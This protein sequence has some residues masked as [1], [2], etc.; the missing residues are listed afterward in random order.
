MNV[1]RWGI[2][3]PIPAALVFVV[4]CVF[5]FW[6][7]R[8]LPI[9]TLP[10][11]TPPEID[12]TVTL[13]GASPS[14]L[15]TDVT[16]KVEDAVA[17]IANID[18]LLSTVNE[19]QSRTRILFELGR[20]M[21]TALEEVRDAIDRVRSELPP[22]IDE[23]QITRLTV[24]GPIML[25]Y[26]V[27]S[28][29]LALDE[30]S[31][32]VD[33]TVKKVL[34]GTPGV[35]TVSRIGGLDRE[36]RVDL[37]PDMLQAFGLTAGTVSMQL[38]RIQV[39][40]AG[41]RTTVGGA[42][43]TVRTIATV[44]SAAELANYPISLPDGRSVRLSTIAT[45]ADSHAEPR[46]MAL[47]NGRPV[48][49]FGIQRAVKTSEVAVGD[50]VRRRI[51]ELAREHPE[52]RFIEVDS[53]VEEARNSYNA[54][55]SMLAEGALLAVAVVWLFLRDRRATWISALA[56][57]LSVIPTFGVMHLLGFSLNLLSLLAMAVVIGILVDD[58]IVEVENI[59]RHRALGK[60][61]MQ[62]AGEAADEIGIA[63]IATSATLAAV[64]IPVAFMPG[65]I[66]LFFREFGWTA[67]TAVLFSLLV[68]RLLTPMLAAYFM[69]RKPAHPAEPAWVRFYMRLV[70]HALDKPWRTLATAFATFV[71]ALALVPLIPRTFVPPNNES[72]STVLLELPPGST[73]QD[74]AA[75]AE[76]TRQLLADLPELKSVFARIGS[77]SG[78]GFTTAGSGNVR[79]AQLN[80][81]FHDERQRSM[82][83]LEV[84]VRRRLEKLA[85]VR[86]SF[87]A[88]GP[89][90]RLEVVVVGRDPVQLAA[91]AQNIET[92]MRGV[93]GLS[94]VQ[95]SASLLQPEIAIIPDPARAAD[96]GVSTVDIAEA[97]RIATTG[98]F[99]RN[100]PKLNLAER[101]I[102]IRVQV[103]EAARDDAS[104]LS[105]MRVPARGGA[106]P[107][108][109]VAEIRDSSG[110]AIIERYN[111]ERNVKISGELNGNPLGPVMNEVRR[112]P[113]VQ[114]LPPGVRILPGGD[115]EAFVDL[116]VGFAL[117][118]LTGV[119][120][121]Y[122]VL[123]ML[124]NS[125]S[126]PLVILAAIPLCGVGAFGALLLTGY[127]L[128]LPS[129]VGLL[130]LTG[131]S[132][133][134]SILIVDYAII[135]ERAG[136]P[137]REAIIDACH[138]R[139]RPVIMTT[140]AMGAGMVPVAF[141]LAAD[142]N[143]R[144]PLGIS[145]IGGLLTS[146]L[147]SLIA[148]PAAYWL[149]AQWVTR[150]KARRAARRQA[151]E[152]RS[153]V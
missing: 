82:Q 50:E 94:G 74:S 29:R 106:V 121:V 75:A 87:A 125:P 104:L 142:G 61:P 80:L 39:E 131:V 5:G 113:A 36:V 65:Q 3:H 58:A 114:N 152:A 78:T 20:D 10:D 68:A 72:R 12:I 42:E 60:T 44:H 43:Q 26:A 109:A 120:S 128:S 123:L 67:A 139:V 138:K 73:L 18:K 63:V 90:D 91:T 150:F 28:D 55:M 25:T 108:S 118:M 54:S 23:P 130:M 47:L 89:G 22:E 137:R 17:G 70:G 81:R 35:G 69:T 15:E 135:G 92:A 1:S 117:A 37:R 115:A 48:V 27:E 96:L 85:G 30:L 103:A 100:L 102:P 86:V 83:Q 124:F 14:Q 7:W 101:Q 140:I 4:L 51:A 8:Q 45:V 153:A 49:G 71:V 40:R 149:V 147:L 34:F 32:F 98:D 134:N 21:D 84:E 105:L 2:A 99:L 52:V 41:G 129:L 110:P 77:V 62:A 93:R 116:F 95:S 141:S 145:V 88:L 126:M 11:F 24:L 122:V 57:P 111:R 56:L 132:T 97:A 13:P 133:K 143:F 66:G 64:F 127:A 59:T 136:L 151:R 16:R 9:S 79:K 19:G 148:V 112:L 46:D 119:L 6:G 107:L 53:V 146:T 38:A 144:A 31:W 76:Q 33:D